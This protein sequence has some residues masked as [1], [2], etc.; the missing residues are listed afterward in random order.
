MQALGAVNSRTIDALRDSC[1]QL[2]SINVSRC[3]LL[4]AA[5]LARLPSSVVDLRASNLA[6]FSD[7]VLVSLFYRFPGLRTLDVSYNR[8]LTDLGWRAVV[9]DSTKLNLIPIEPSEASPHWLSS[10]LTLVEARRQPITADKK[11]PL[12]NL[13]HL[14]LTRC[15]GLTDQSL[16]HL[17]SCV[18][19]LK[20][21]EVAHMSSTAFQSAG[22]VKLL[23]T[24]P[25]PALTHFDLEHGSLLTDD[26]LVALV[27]S[28]SMQSLTHLV[29]S[30]CE[31]FTAGAIARVCSGGNGRGACPNLRV[32]EAD[33]TN[34]DDGAARSFVAGR[35]VPSRVTQSTEV[36][37]DSDRESSTKDGIV[38]ARSQA[39]VAAS[40]VVD[41]A[42]LSL[43]DA[44]FVSRST[45]RAFASSSVPHGRP[46]NDD[47]ERSLHTRPRTGVRA[48]WP[49]VTLGPTTSSSDRPRG[50]HH[51]PDL[52]L[53][54]DDGEAQ[55]SGSFQPR[56]RS[57]R[58]TLDECDP[59]RVVVRSFYGSLAVDAADAARSNLHDQQQ[60]QR[61]DDAATPG[62]RGSTD[63]RRLSITRVLL[64]SRTRAMSDSAV[65]A[66][67][68]RRRGSSLTSEGSCVIS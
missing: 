35:V 7:T 20:S 45:Q 17:A 27:E 31:Q 4:R 58:G 50:Y 53:P 33:G 15:L 9:A 28:R 36:G 52:E 32:L 59:S 10:F 13:E 41:P 66:T 11:R 54:D 16:A 46:H 43:L 5:S 67:G 2:T 22:I 47:D 55:D 1:R 38:V 23:R 65:A 34:I 62:S 48:Y 44:R 39:T 64:G 60:Q 26:V 56:V 25:A 12:V 37:P 29:L 42:V 63:G 68:T 3:P 24:S 49:T 14:N 18:P 6:S 30:S 8:Q 51:A 57:R 19:S 21:L 40:K 61:L